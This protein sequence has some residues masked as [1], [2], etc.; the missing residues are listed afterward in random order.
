[1]IIDL[2]ILLKNAINICYFPRSWKCAK[3]LPILKKGKSHDG[4]SSYRPISLTPSL[5][6]IFEAVINDSIVSFCT[7]NNIIPDRQF[8]FKY[9]HST[10]HAI[11][12]LLSNLN[13]KVGNSQLVGA[14][15]LDLESFDS[16]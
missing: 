3:V 5:S 13:T 7:D 4:P 15:F 11:H 9:Q 2:I 14:A 16:V 1:M 6:K 12:K 10:V 8:G